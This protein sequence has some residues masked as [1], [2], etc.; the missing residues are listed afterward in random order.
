MAR[1]NDIARPDAAITTTLPD[2]VRALL[3][4]VVAAL[5]V[6]LADRFEDDTTRAELLSGRASD[7]RI[8]LASVLRGDDI[9]HAAQHL[10]EWTA[11]R[12]VTFT[13]WQDRAAVTR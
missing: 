4:A 10:Q 5:D 7:A 9:A 13:S 6:P 1:T 8:T 2:D 3:A 11:A 12:P